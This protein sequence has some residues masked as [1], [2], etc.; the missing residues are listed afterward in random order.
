[1]P[2]I[3]LVMVIISD[4]YALELMLVCIRAVLKAM[5]QMRNRS[6]GFR[7][8]QAIKYGSNAGRHG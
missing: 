8:V 6:R 3:I 1:M 2:A 7:R 4:S 5:H